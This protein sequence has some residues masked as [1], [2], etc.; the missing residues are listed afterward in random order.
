MLR[1]RSLETTRIYAKLDTAEAVRCTA[2]MAG[3][4]IVSRRTT[5]QARID[6]FLA[7]HQRLGAQLHL[8]D[9][10]LSGFAHYV[11]SRHHRGALTV[12]LMADRVRHDN[13]RESCV[14]AAGSRS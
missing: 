12:E 3:K 10:L 13:A 14:R 2:A 1:H 7:E 9:T 8:W 5:L 11:A 4:R 6:A